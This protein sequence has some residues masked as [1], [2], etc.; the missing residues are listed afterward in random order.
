MRSFAFWNSPPTR[1][2][3]AATLL[4]P[5]GAI[6]AA[7]TA[8]RLR[9]PGYIAAIPV[10]CIGNLNA[11]G[12]GKTPTAIALIERLVSRGRV[13]HVVSRGHGGRLTG[14]VRVDPLS[15]TAADVG[16]EPMLLSAFAPTFIARDR[17]A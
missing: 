13:V 10:I 15:H 3:V 14:P 16:D 1:P 17:S 9:K 6:Y 12:T 5:L 4:A 8:F 7:A 11:G 2:G